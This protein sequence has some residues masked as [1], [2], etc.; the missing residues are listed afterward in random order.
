MSTVQTKETVIALLG[1]PN[2]G[3][4]T[5]FNGLTGLRQHVGN[6]PGKTVE[7]AEGYISQAGQRFRLVDL[8]GYGYAKVSGAEKRRWSDLIEGYFQTC[9]SAERDLRLTLLLVDMRHPPSRDDR[10]MMDYLAQMTLP[11]LV[12]LTKADKLNKSER[13][14]RMEALNEELSAYEG[15]TL[16]PFSVVT[17]ENVEELRGILESVID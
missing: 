16:L 11:F 6:W 8:P 3:K 12:V 9:A 14:T 10:L 15:L 5:L 7:R 17:G 2:S 13:A 1:Q 4:S